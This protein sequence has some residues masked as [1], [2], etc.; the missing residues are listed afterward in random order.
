MKRTIGRPINRTGS[1]ALLLIGM[2]LL[3]PD[4]LSGWR[5]P[6]ADFVGTIR[7]VTADGDQP[8]LL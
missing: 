2:A 8:S 4:R 5:R 6:A 1:A 7:C 3:R